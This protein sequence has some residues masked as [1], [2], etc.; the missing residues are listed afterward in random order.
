MRRSVLDLHGM[1]LVPGRTSSGSGGLRQE[2]RR[3]GAGTW[4]VN[5]RAA[6]RGRCHASS[7]LFI[8]V[9][10]LPTGRGQILSSEW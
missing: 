3:R 5:G 9:R 10:V 6:A 2:V 7:P 4:R 1:A 8:V